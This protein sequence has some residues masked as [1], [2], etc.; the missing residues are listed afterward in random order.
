MLDRVEKMIEQIKVEQAQKRKAELAML[1]SQINPHFLFNILNSIR[2]RIM[3][4]GD[5]ENAELLFSL[6]RLLRMTIQQRDEYTSLHDE[7]HI[8]RSYVELLNFR[9]ADEV[10][11]D[12]DCTSESLGVKIPRFLLQPVIEN[13][14]IHGLRQESGRILI[15]TWTQDSRLLIAIEDNGR[16]M[17]EVTLNRLRAEVGSEPPEL[18][19]MPSSR[20]AHIGMSNV[21]E[22]LYL[23]Y[24]SAFQVT[25][26][27]IPGQGTTFLFVL[28]EEIPDQ[29]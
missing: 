10:T 11:L 22:R 9:Q 6:S 17:D 24:G 14:Y 5:E 16:G 2:L 29:G 15:R 4:R 19:A 3:M 13:A 21:Y 27:S 1:Q 25:I 8:V 12:T 18:E 26:D 20:L 7:L 23:T 28:P